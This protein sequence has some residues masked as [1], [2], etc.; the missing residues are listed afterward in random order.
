MS[1]DEFQDKSQEEEQLIYEEP[2]AYQRM[3]IEH[4][5][6]GTFP[7]PFMKAWII[8]ILATII[9]IIGFSFFDPESSP[10]LAQIEMLI[11]IITLCLTGI[12]TQSKLRSLITFPTAIIINAIFYYLPMY[13]FNPFGLWL[14]FLGKDGA[15]EANLDKISSAIDADL[16]AVPLELLGWILDIAFLFLI[17]PL[18]AI[19]FAALTTGISRNVA[20]MP[21]TIVFKAITICLLLF[22]ILTL[23]FAYM[24]IAKGT[25]GIAYLALGATAALDDSGLDLNNLNL[26][27]LM[28]NET[29]LIQLTSSFSVAN[30]YIEEASKSFDFVKYNFLATVLLDLLG[31]SDMLELLDA[32]DVLYYSVDAAPGVL[33]G[34]YNLFQGLDQ[35]FNAL[36]SYVPPSTTIPASNLQQKALSTSAEYTNDFRI[37]LRYLQRAVGNFSTS[38]NPLAEAISQLEELTKLSSVEG[39]EIDTT[40][41]TTMLEGFESA[42]PLFLEIGDVLIDF[43][44]GTYMSVLAINSVGENDFIQARDWLEQSSAELANVTS[45]LDFDTTGVWEPVMHAVNVFGDMTEILEH[46]VK[47]AL[48]GTRTFLTLNNTLV[49]LNE[50][51][52]TR[53]PGTDPGGNDLLWN[54]VNTG[55]ADGRTY[56]DN[57]TAELLTAGDLATL[58]SAKNYGDLTSVFTPTFGLISNIIN[59]Y[60]GN[61]TQLDYLLTALDSTYKSY[62]S[63]SFGTGEFLKVIGSHVAPFISSE[64]DNATIYINLARDNVSTAKAALALCDILP[65]SVISEWTNLLSDG[66]PVYEE[67]V[68]TLPGTENNDDMLGLCQTVLYTINLIASADPLLVDAALDYVESLNLWAIFN[69]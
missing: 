46:F 59:D 60:K 67:P 31:Y 1:N 6:E 11:V 5:D 8:S 65:S 33:L 55:L 69:S 20:L 44:N 40:G 41:I 63:F 38:I 57:L 52:V 15:V 4:K 47:G 50:V 53:P 3:P 42:L 14:R 13:F 28:E 2:V 29:A 26:D 62:Y 34:I 58:Y 30:E 19:L 25:E 61:M 22:L 16:S 17:F 39:L 32:I 36:P 66:N 64:F 68:T 21:V 37:G 35:T 45:N 7:L 9:T 10:I 23:P 12:L 18:I 24:G 27:Q 48:S 49:V 56:F 51:N 43:I 54:G